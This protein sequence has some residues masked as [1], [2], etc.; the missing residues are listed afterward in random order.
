MIEIDKN[1]FLPSFSITE[2]AF[3]LN[4]R[5]RVGPLGA[6]AVLKKKGIPIN[7]N[8]DLPSTT[9]TEGAFFL[10][11]LNKVFPAGAAPVII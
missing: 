3:F 2:G 1:I 8:I 9:K 4:L 6:A 10:N 5:N 7:K 11:R